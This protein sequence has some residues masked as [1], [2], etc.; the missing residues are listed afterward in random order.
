M[1]NNHGITKGITIATIAAAAILHASRPFEGGLSAFVVGLF[2]WSMLPYAVCLGVALR[3]NALAA[4][5]GAIAALA[6]DGFMH[7]RVFVAP[8][9]STEALG[10]LSAPLANLF[11]F[12]PLGMLAGLGISRWSR[13]RTT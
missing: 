5:G 7:Y 8:T 13:P 6:I 3:G 4:P 1:I 10:L 11:V 2:V 12:V 9:S